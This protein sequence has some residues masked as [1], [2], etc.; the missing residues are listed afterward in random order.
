MPVKISREQIIGL[1]KTDLH[2]H[3]DGS[4]IPETI[5]KLAKNEK[6]NLIKEGKKY[7]YNLKVASAEEIEKKIFKDSYKNLAEYLMAFE[8][9]NCV[10]RSAKNLEE[11]AYRVACDE[12]NEGVR[13][14]E[15]RF[16]PQKHW[17][18]NLGWE[19]IIKAVDRGLRKAMKE[20]NSKKEIK[21]HNELPYRCGIILCAMRMIKPEMADY[22]HQLNKFQT[23]HDLQ[24]LAT[25]ASMEVAKLAVNSRG[26][27]YLVAGFDL[28]GNEDGYPAGLYKGAFEYCYNNGVQTTCHAGE[29]YGPESIMD[30]MKYCHV[31]RIGHGTQLFQWKEI[32][33]RNEDGSDLTEKQK[34]E[35]VNN[36]AERL[37]KERTTIEVCLKSNSQTTPALR[38]LSKHPVQN[39]LKYSLRVALSTD[40]RGISKV[41]VADEYMTFIKLYSPNSSILKN[42]CLAGFKGAFFPGTYAEHRIYMRK[43]IDFYNE[44]FKKYIG[45]YKFNNKLTA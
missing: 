35:Y 40:N 10:L 3:L 27:G 15:L 41:S 31:R 22:Y 39:F 20:Y 38:N 21:K 45:K 30:A 34:K 42:L 6:I 37:A 17:T 4:V 33:F 36:L 26:K 13:Y 1:P 29:A 12:F 7:G 5:V 25:M 43:A 23:G 2:V 19:E 24:S 11:A 8:F 44:C 32:K 14:F 18:E 28:A 9:V 16:A